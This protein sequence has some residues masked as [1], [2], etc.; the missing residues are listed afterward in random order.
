MNSLF[1]KAL[2]RLENIANSGSKYELDRIKMLLSFL[3]D[4][5]EKM[6]II[7]ITGTKGKGSTG[8]ILSGLLKGHV[9]T[10]FFSSPH[11]N[12]PNERIRIDNEMITEM[13][14][15]ENLS[16]IWKYIEAVK[17][18]TGLFPSYFET[19][20][21]LAFYTFA[22]HNIEVGI[23]EV[24]LGG[25]LDATN[26][27]RG[28]ICILTRIDYDHTK[29]LGDTLSEIAY[30]KAGII[31]NRSIVVNINRNKEILSVIKDKCSEKE[32]FYNTPFKRRKIKIIN[33]GIDFSDIEIEKNGKVIFSTKFPLGGEHQIENLSIALTA[34][35]C[36]KDIGYPVKIKN[37]D[38]NNIVW[39]GRFEIIRKKPL[40]F[41]DGAHNSI[42]AKRLKEHIKSIYPEG[43][44]VLAG[45][46]ADKDYR[47]FIKELSHITKNI[48]V[49]DVDSK[50]NLDSE[51]FA[52]EF[53]NIS[54]D[55]EVIVE[56]NRKE[57]FNKAL[58]LSK[59]TRLPMLITGSLY[60]IGEYKKGH[61]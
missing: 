23:V 10:G 26:V 32:A 21:A 44:V 11:L 42:S 28:D 56:K 18:K 40:V 2:S 57:A 41:I 25:R 47:Y 48:V 60:L 17:E 31:K 35:D 12:Q 59:K 13:E 46:L 36:M 34:I 16:E 1:L 30:E 7:H 29:T 53:S 54:P 5:Q 20:T 22:K 27:A 6:K 8:A 4:P 39:P 3:G 37:E 51:I 24:G 55:S 61:R 33:K 58:M 15:S 38:F 14:F 52:K 45:I 50:R 43:V 49:T 19:I 9:K